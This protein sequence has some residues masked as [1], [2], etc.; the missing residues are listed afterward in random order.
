[1]KNPNYD[2]NAIARLLNQISKEIINILNNS[3]SQSSLKNLLQ[4]CL[5]NCN[6]SIRDK[7]YVYS[8]QTE[9]GKTMIKVEF[10]FAGRNTPI[11]ICFETNFTG[12]TKAKLES[13]AIIITE[14]FDSCLDGLIY[15][16]C[17]AYNSLLY[18]DGF[19]D[20]CIH[21]DEIHWVDSS[22]STTNFPKDNLFAYNSYNIFRD[23]LSLEELER[24]KVLDINLLNLANEVSVE[25]PFLKQLLIDNSKKYFD[26]SKFTHVVYGLSFMTRKETYSQ[27]M[28]VLETLNKLGREND[29]PIMSDKD[30][31][32]EPKATIC[33][34]KAKTSIENYYAFTQDEKGK[35]LTLSQF[36]KDY[37]IT[38]KGAY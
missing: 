36:Y 33:V 16:N 38:D 25:F 20:E 15:S 27:C 7:Y 24:M 14:N 3:P 6:L 17:V 13:P 19:S 9:L 34:E 4:F 18:V 2:I 32:K 1:M 10:Y 28:K 5:S 35:A 29:I 23:T 11:S 8:P 37:G 31:L 26:K 21:N 12:S 22:E 30:Y